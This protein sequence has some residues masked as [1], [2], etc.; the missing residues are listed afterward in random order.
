M[1][2]A[3]RIV[4]D[5]NVFLGAL[6][7]RGAANAVVAACL[8]GQAIPLMGTTLLAEYEDILGRE[9]LFARCRLSAVE[10]EELL[11]IFLGICEWTPI[12]FGWRPNLV[13][14]GDNHLIELAVAGQSRYLVT[15]N[16]RDL[17]RMELRFPELRVCSPEDFLRELTS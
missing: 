8:R 16:L 15:R 12:Y 3:Q 9:S 5:T 14:E 10:R 7:T 11:D 1:S 13:D 17:A 4:V 2:V 6:L